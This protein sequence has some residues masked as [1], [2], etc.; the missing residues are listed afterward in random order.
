MSLYSQGVST[1]L[2]SP[3]LDAAK[4]YMQSK[5]YRTTK[6]IQ[7]NT[8]LNR[9]II[10][11][12]GADIPTAFT[13]LIMRNWKSAVE[14]AFRITYYFIN[15]L[16]IPTLIVPF[17][18]KLAK[19]KFD[20]PKDFKKSFYTEFEDLLPEKR[21]DRDCEKF[22]GKLKDLEGEDAVKSFLGNDSKEHKNKIHD[23]MDKL[24]KAKSYVVKSD[25]LVGGLLTY[26]VP[27][28][29]TWFSKKVLGVTSYVGE[30]DYLDSGQQEESIRFH[31]KTKYLK[32]GLGLLPTIFGS[33]WYS[34]KVY[35]VATKTQ[36][37]IQDNSVSK[38]V[39]RNI[40]QYDY[41][42]GIYANKL[43][44]AGT[45]LFGGDFGFLLSCRSLNELI[46]KTLRLAVFWPTMFF[47]VEWVNYKLSENQDKKYGT[48]IVDYESPKELGIRQVKSLETL[49]EELI[50]AEKEGD[51][52]R[53]RLA[54]GSI[55]GQVSNYWK[56]ILID[57][58]VMGVGLTSANIIGTKIRVEKFGIY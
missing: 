1:V 38:F 19:S 52:E 39:R 4:S 48:S 50:K 33:N 51:N 35:E 42:R 10:E 15:S 2:Q 58:V 3:A 45:V 56:S 30:L 46:E 11:L 9:G 6:E 28:T 18:N 21:T 5:F 17:L 55:K 22:I 31:E 8:I 20:L 34:N 43:N 40:K 53:I 44:I 37:E 47:G 54:S 26:F 16:V 36:E 49:E 57:S 23:F 27:W 24:I 25:V 41:H 14:S 13:E 32:F 12:L 29:T 7:H